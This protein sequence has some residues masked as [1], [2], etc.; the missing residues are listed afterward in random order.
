MAVEQQ[1]AEHTVERVQVNP[2]PS[3]VDEQPVGNGRM[4]EFEDEQEEKQYEIVVQHAHDRQTS[5]TSMKLHGKLTPL[6]SPSEQQPSAVEY[7]HERMNTEERVLNNNLNELLQIP[8][9]HAFNENSLR[10]SP[11]TSADAQ[12]DR[13]LISMLALKDLRNAQQEH[14]PLEAQPTDSEL[15]YTWSK[16]EDEKQSIH[17][18]DEMEEQVASRRHEVYVSGES[19]ELYGYMNMLAELQEK[20][21]PETH[22]NMSVD[23]N[24]AVME[25]EDGTDVT[26]QSD[27]TKVEYTM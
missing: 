23:A 10:P 9:T 16:P 27:A 19:D 2:H 5:N 24:A 3:D 12:Y 15:M 13:V 17:G 20:V 26:P 21:S 22:E 11:T 14:P 6:D 4:D 7:G 18:N 1:L 8:S 25:T